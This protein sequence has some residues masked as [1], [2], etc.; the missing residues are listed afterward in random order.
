[1]PR[2]I[3]GLPGR[4]REAHVPTKRGTCEV[5][6]RVTFRFHKTGSKRADGTD[7]LQR[8]CPACANET[9]QMYNAQ[10]KGLA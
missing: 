1:M 9:Q 6:G 7:V 3:K 8:R 2:Q 5:H 10:R 4:P